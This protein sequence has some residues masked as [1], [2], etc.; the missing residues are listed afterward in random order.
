[1]VN[2]IK[3]FYDLDLFKKD[4]YW[5]KQIL[6]LVPSNQALTGTRHPTL[7]G[8]FFTTRTLPGIFWKISGFR[9][10]TIH[11]VF[12]KLLHYYNNDA[13]NL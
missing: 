7:P 6:H 11:A 3:Y 10:V 4:P 1:M 8:L 9:V 5:V 13:S 2:L 12:S